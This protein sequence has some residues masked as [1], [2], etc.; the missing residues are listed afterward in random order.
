MA[1][2]LC[3]KK[4]R[5]L[6]MAP[7][8]LYVSCCLRL[9]PCCHYVL[10]FLKV[11]SLAL[12]LSFVFLPLAMFCG[13]FRNAAVNMTTYERSNRSMYPHLRGGNP[14]DQ[15]LARNLQ[16][17]FGLFTLHTPS[18]APHSNCRFRQRQLAQETALH[19]AKLG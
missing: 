14:F 10:S 3:C 19:E 12:P 2:S 16:E 17:F 1:A 13:I 18:F 15:G 9:T 11:Y 4:L 5:L 8:G 6:A 7:P